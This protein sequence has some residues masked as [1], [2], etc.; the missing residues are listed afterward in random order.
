[1]HNLNIKQT[2]AD[3]SVHYVKKVNMKFYCSKGIILGE[4]KD[5]GLTYDLIILYYLRQGII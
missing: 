1:M 2:P 3:I 5:Y 4:K